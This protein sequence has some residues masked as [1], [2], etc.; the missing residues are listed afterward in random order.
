M[1][2]QHAVD[3]LINGL[4]KMQTLAR[5]RPLAPV[6][7]LVPALSLSLRAA[8]GFQTTFNSRQDRVMGRLLHKCTAYCLQT[9]IVKASA[10][11]FATHRSAVRHGVMQ[12]VSKPPH[13]R[14]SVS[15]LV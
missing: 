10:A 5:L 15:I 1:A 12:Q 9:C 14:P 3:Q 6:Q 8:S 13:M 7:V 11:C 2:L 4:L